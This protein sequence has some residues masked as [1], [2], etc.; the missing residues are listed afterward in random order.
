[1]LRSKIQSAHSMLVCHISYC[2]LQGQYFQPTIKLI[3][4]GK[5]G[6]G[7]GGGQTCSAKTSFYSGFAGILEV[8]NSGVHNSKLPAKRTAISYRLCAHQRCHNNLGNSTEIHEDEKL[9]SHQAFH[10]DDTTTTKLYR[11]WLVS[12]H[13]QRSQGLLTFH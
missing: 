9:S 3:D 13:V 4:G 11:R 12:Y 1:M 2:K 8:G 10:S 6:L 5:Y 7:L